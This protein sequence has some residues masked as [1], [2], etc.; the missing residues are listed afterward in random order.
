MNITETL[1]QYELQHCPL[2]TP[3]FQQYN[4]QYRILSQAVTEIF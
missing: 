2:I 1:T 3:S 4:Q